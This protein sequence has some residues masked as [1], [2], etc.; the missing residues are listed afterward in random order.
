MDLSSRHLGA[1][2]L[3]LVA[4]ATVSANAADMPTKAYVPPPVVAQVYN[5][6]G[7]YVGVN[8]GFG[9]GSQETVAASG[10]IPTNSI[11]PTVS[12]HSLW[13]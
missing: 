9:W 12:A 11:H 13:I 3:M 7:L 2:A 4:T 8:G 6:T 1:A 10:L 5:W